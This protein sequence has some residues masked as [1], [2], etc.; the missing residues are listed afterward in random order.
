MT[1]DGQ[2]YLPGTTVALERGR[3]SIATVARL[4]LKLRAEKVYYLLNPAYREPVNLF[5]PQ[6]GLALPPAGTGL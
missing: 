2:T 5:Y 4:R 3:H 6:Q 1:I